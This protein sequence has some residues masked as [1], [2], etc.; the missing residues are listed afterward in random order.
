MFDNH[1]FVIAIVLSGICA[2]SLICIPLI[3]YVQAGKVSYPIEED[4]RDPAPKYV[5][6]AR[7]FFDGVS[8]QT[9]TG[10]ID[11]SMSQ[12]ERQRLEKELGEAGYT[13]SIL[14]AEFVMAKWGS[15]LVGLVVTA[16]L[17]L[18]Y[19]GAAS[20]AFIMGAMV[21]AICYIY[22]D[23]KLRQMGRLRKLLLEKQFPF[24]L[25][26]LVLTMRAGQAQSVA[27]NYAVDMTPK[28]PVKQE[29]SRAVSEINAGVSRTEALQKVAQ[30][31]RLPSLSN[32]VAAFCQADKSGGSLTVSLSE[33]ARQRRR[34]RFQ[35][36]EKLAGQAPVKLLVPLF[37][38]I[39]PI[40]F[41]IIGVPILMDLKG[42]GLLD[43]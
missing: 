3:M 16:L 33:Q 22:P 41:I 5:A 27:L 23:I 37:L 13:Y 21:A 28:G 18:A 19:G 2:A 43:R 32:F 42:S 30:R 12:K 39:F 36:A 15:A 14:P 20:L 29:F 40:L 1:L 9:A 35:K 17:V 7:N 11:R 8:N 6:M 25:D 38:F 10:Y 26:V 4:W 31:V 24:F 34:E